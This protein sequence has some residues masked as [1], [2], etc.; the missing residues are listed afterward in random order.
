[1]AQW[2]AFVTWQPMRQGL[3]VCRSAS[4]IRRISRTSLPAAPA[5]LSEVQELDDSNGGVHPY[6]DPKLG[7]SEKVYARFFNDFDSR[8]LF[9]WSKSPKGRCSVFFVR[10]KL[11]A[12]GAF[13]HIP[14][15]GKRYRCR[16]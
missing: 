16:V 13:R 9:F 1:M 12:S 5:Q 14:S 10:K 8:G 15:C 3:L 2:K 7:G 11:G 6:M 4:A